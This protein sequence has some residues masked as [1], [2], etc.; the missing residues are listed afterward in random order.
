MY[1]GAGWMDWQCC[2]NF[3]IILDVCVLDA[4]LYDHRCCKSQAINPQSIQR[5]HEVLSVH[6]KFSQQLPK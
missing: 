1:E 4:D 6:D 5:N 3:T 2:S